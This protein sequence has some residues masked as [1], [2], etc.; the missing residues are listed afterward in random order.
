VKKFSLVHF[1]TREKIFSGQLLVSMV[2]SHWNVRFCSSCSS[3]SSGSCTPY[4]FLREPEEPEEPEAQWSTL[5]MSW[6]WVRFLVL[7]FIFLC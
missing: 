5:M 4:T 6:S 2:M 7:T 1:F 3:G